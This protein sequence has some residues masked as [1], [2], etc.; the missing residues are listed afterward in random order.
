VNKYQSKAVTGIRFPGS[1]VSWRQRLQTFELPPALR[2][3]VGFVPVSLDTPSAL[4]LL[5]CN[6]ELLPQSLIGSVNLSILNGG[7]LQT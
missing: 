6:A 3:V 2:I 5:S 1:S 4:I 7:L